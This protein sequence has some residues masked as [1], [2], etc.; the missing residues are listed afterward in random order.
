[1]RRVAGQM[2]RTV[3][4]AGGR[5]RAAGVPP[6]ARPGRK[7]PAGAVNGRAAGPGARASKIRGSAVSSPPARP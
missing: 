2:S 4:P 3:E 5:A 6:F 7:P 1:M